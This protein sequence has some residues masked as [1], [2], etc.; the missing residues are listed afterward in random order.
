MSK[1]SV[2]LS[3]RTEEV[4]GFLSDEKLNNKKNYSGSINAGL[5]LLNQL[6]EQS[7]PDLTDSEWSIIYNTYAGCVLEFNLPIRIASDIMDSLGVYD[8]GKLDHD[9]AR[10]V[11]KTSEM[12][13]CQQVAVLWQAKRF[14][15]QCSG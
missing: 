4:I 2:Y 1:R 3:E 7:K 12:T 14:W 11:E 6:M 9:T 15:Q 5:V 8:I 13:Q 10:L